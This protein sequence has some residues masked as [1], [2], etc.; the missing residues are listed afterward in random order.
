MTEG[1]YRERTR[2]EE[3]PCTQASHTTRPPPLSV[4]ADQA[5]ASGAPVRRHHHL[6]LLLFPSFPINPIRPKSVSE[7]ALFLL[8]SHPV[9]CRGLFS[10]C[11]QQLLQCSRYLRVVRTP[12]K[13]TNNPLYT[14]K[15]Y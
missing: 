6:L 2:R 14:D 9:R 15:T 5:D 4:R 7:V 8:V 12:L 1:P 13:Q 3:A 11:H 10:V